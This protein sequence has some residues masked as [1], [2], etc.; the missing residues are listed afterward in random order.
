MDK[1]HKQAKETRKKNAEARIAQA[2]KRKSE[3]MAQINALRQVRDHPDTTPSE[4]LRAVELLMEFEK[5]G[6]RYI[7]RNSEPGG[8]LCRPLPRLSLWVK[9]RFKFCK[10]QTKG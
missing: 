1:N 5:M 3:T 10:G 2:M 9:I 6:Y 4:R 7:E 8:V